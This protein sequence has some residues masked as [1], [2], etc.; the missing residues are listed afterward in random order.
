MS[1]TLTTDIAEA[2][3]EGFDKHYRLFRGASRT[4]RERFERADWAEGREASKTRIEMYDQRVREAVLNVRERFPAAGA[5]E[6]LW[7]HI[8]AA[9]IGLLYDHHQP[10]CAETFYN[11][12]ACRVLDRRYFNNQYIFWR[13]A[14]ST[15]HLDDQTPTYRCYYP[16]DGELRV[17][18]REI[19]QGLGLKNPFENLE[20]DLGWIG[21]ATA[22]KFPEGAERR[23]NFQLQVLTSLFFRNKAAYV[24]G[25]AQNGN[26]IFPFVL[27]LLQ[28]PAGKLYVDTVLAETRHIGRLLSLARAYFMVD[29][30]V[31]SAYVDFL[32][33]L[34]PTRPKAE[35]YTLVGL[36]KQGKT[37][38]YRDLHRHLLHST[39]KFVLAPGTRGMVMMVFTLPSF[40]YV[41]KVIRDWFS[42]PKDTDPETVRGRYLL[43]KYHDRVGRMADTLEFSD[44]AFPKD[45]F[46]PSLL[47]E[48]ARIAP[49]SLQT[50]GDRYVIKHLYV[51]RRLI[52]LDV[53]LTG[54][55]EGRLREGIEEYGNSVKDLA[56]ANIFPGDLLLKNFGMTRYGRVVFYDYDEVAYLTDCN[57]RALP[58]ATRNEE[59][60][61]S[62]PWFS[63]G[64]HDVFPEQFP[65]FLFPPGRARDLFMEMHGELADPGFWISKQERIRQGIQDDVFPYPEG[66]RFKNRFP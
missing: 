35:L 5:D 17:T 10:E 53:Y 24:V 21:L 48:F 11:T 23:P 28:T 54:A 47:E 16:G 29:M 26:D 3:L 4:A 41:F 56:S 22:G 46:H 49:S 7:P 58:S 30:E 34:L 63:V 18:F 13:P 25:R 12:V 55:D 39:D 52:P 32:Q 36:Q 9:F 59:E 6:S 42:P 1:Y 60:L 44:V 57:F 2:I 40:P 62:E 19:L 38:H 33:T 66:I 31:P 50:D 61:S 65:T 8:K 27:P 20:R 51:E 37:L 43:V 45:R 64:A 14:V 15:E